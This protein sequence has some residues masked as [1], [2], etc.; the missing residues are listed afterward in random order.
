M[1][2]VWYNPFR[3]DEYGTWYDTFLALAGTSPFAAMWFIFLKG[4]WVIIVYLAWVMFKGLW[5]EHKTT[6]F[7]LK[8]NWVYLAIDIPRLHEQTPRAVENLFAHLAGAHSPATWTEKWFEGKTQ[9]TISV[10]I[11]SIGGHTQF[12]IRTTRNLRDMIEASVYAQYPDAEITEVEDY[13]LRVPSNYPDREW[14]MFGTEMIPVKPDPYPLRTYPEFEDKVSGELKDPM[15][16]FLENMS[17]IGPNE[18]IWYQIVL[19]PIDQ[20]DFRTKGELLVKKITGQKIVVKE[21]LLE[22]AVGLPI[23]AASMLIEG[24]GIL[25]ETAPTKKKEEN[26]LMTRMLQMTPGERKVVEA[27]ENKISKLVFNAK[28]RFLYIAKK[29]A[30]AKGRVV[31]PFIGAIKQFNTNDLQSLKPE[32]KKVG[33]NSGL[34]FFKAQRNNARKR[35]FMQMYRRRSNWAGTPNWCMNIEELATMWHFPI[36]IQTRATQLKKTEFK[37]AEPPLNLPFGE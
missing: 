26:P 21:S 15:A 12:I 28:I 35:R 16:V 3:M 17:R 30:F 19:T 4:G 24:S 11:V 37:R 22:K 13:T 29:E 25:G 1:D 32:T 6:E 23:K 36:S 31:M 18:Q 10:E 2:E 9:D 8:K 20:K 34:W 5:M 7:T 14:E 33:M 27:V